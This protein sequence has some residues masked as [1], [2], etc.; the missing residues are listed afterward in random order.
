M[1]AIVFDFKIAGVDG[2]EVAAVSLVTQLQEPVG[3]AVRA[4]DARR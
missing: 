3:A 1:D 4:A 2:N